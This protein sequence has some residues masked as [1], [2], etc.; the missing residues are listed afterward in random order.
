MVCNFETGARERRFQAVVFLRRVH[1]T[2]RKGGVKVGIVIVS[3]MMRCDTRCVGAGNGMMILSNRPFAAVALI[4]V[5]SITE[6]ILRSNKWRD[7]MRSRS[8]HH[9][10]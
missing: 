7:S 10:G 5:R 3:Q 6:T 8:K 1:P 9:S 4:M 2:S